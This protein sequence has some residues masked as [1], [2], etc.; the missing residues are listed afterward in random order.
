MN[1]NSEQDLKVEQK[2]KIRHKSQTAACNNRD[3]G[4]YLLLIKTSKALEGDRARSD[5][6]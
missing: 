3:I 5:G 1:N 6:G 2:C 4:I